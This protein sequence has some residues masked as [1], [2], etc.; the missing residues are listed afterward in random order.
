LQKE[1]NLTELSKK[2]DAALFNAEQPFLIGI[3]HLAKNES[4]DMILGQKT[5]AL[6]WKFEAYSKEQHA[7][8][9][10]KDL[11]EILNS[12]SGFLYKK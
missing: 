10:L 1:E 9:A 12:K 2:Y 5:R 4:N 8:K 11:Q 7:A 3:Y 6:I